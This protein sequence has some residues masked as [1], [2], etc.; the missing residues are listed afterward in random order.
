M[1]L[2]VTPCSFFRSMKFITEVDGRGSRGGGNMALVGVL[3]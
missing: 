1:Y 2:F 3:F